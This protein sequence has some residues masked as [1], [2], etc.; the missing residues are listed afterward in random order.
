MPVAPGN[1]IDQEN[2]CIKYPTYIIICS[3]IVMHISEESWEIKDIYI[4]IAVDSSAEYK[5]RCIKCCNILHH[6]CSYDNNVC[7]EK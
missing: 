3:T 7:V 4:Y 1:D 2:M 5:Q 6:I